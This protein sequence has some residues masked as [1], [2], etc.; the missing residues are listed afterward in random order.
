L[1]PWRDEWL[2]LGEGFSGDVWFLELD[3]EPVS[4]DLWGHDGRFCRVVYKSFVDW[5]R[6]AASGGPGT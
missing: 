5:A 3:R 2:W 6:Q 4:I 1:K